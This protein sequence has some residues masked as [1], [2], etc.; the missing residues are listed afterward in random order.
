MILWSTFV[1]KLNNLDHT[2]LTRWDEVFHALVA[3]NVAKHPLKPTL[4]DDPYL[5]YDMKKWGENHVWLHKPILPFWQIALSFTLFG[6]ST[7]A[8]RLPSALFAT[9]SVL[10]TYLIGAEW[11][12]RRT[13]LIAA[14]LQ[15]I[16]PFLVTLV[17][18]YVFADHVDV[19]L[20]FWVEVGIYFLLR[21]LR[22]GSW[23]DLLIAGFAQG[24]AFLSKSYLAGILLG[25]ALTAWLLP[26]CRLSKRADCQ[27]GPLRILAMLGVTALTVAPWLTYCM[28]Q[29]PD[30][31]WQEEMHTWRHLSSNIEGWAAPWDRVVFDYLI[32]IHGVFYGPMLVAGVVLVGPAFARRQA[33]LWLT[34][35]WALGVV[36][37][38]LFAA[39][40]TPSATLLALPPLLLLLGHLIAEA[41]RGRLWSLAALTGVLIASLVF[42]AVIRS[43]GYG[44]PSPRGF[45]TLMFQNTWVLYQVAGA[46]A[47]VGVVAIAWLIMRKRA[48]AHSGWCRGLRLVASLFCAGVLLWLAGKTVVA[49]WT[50]TSRDSNEPAIVEVGEFARD[51]L[52]PNAVLL[53]E[54]RKG[55]EHLMIMFYADRTCYA[56]PWRN[57]DAIAAKIVEADGIPYVIARRQMPLEVVHQNRDGGLVI[58]RWEAKH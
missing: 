42:P 58:Y 52:P 47:F 45:G 14:T 37:P 54:N 43:P 10:F 17:Q 3:R 32:G 19:S 57:L 40:K 25:V 26:I 18:G 29:Y 2:S 50:V 8:L 21:S 44:Y 56:L 35:A 41:S 20:L 36:I 28:S 51:Q 16:N 33:G 53:C 38:H 13:A 23:R 6:V 24:L 39:T 30:E 12:D 7:F 9:G 31:F 34:Y 11:F 49:A 1:I 27:I 5:P 55:Y 4:V 48:D 22:N 15:A 46:L